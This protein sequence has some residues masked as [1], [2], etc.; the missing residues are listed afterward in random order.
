MI[1][2]WSQHRLAIVHDDRL[3]VLQGEG[4]P[5]V[6]HALLELF[7]VQDPVSTDNKHQNTNVEDILDTFSF[8]FASPAGLPPRRQYDHFIPLI[9]GAWSVSMRPYGIAPEL[10]SELE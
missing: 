10:K 8:V 7:L 3:V 1:T 9:P 4:A 6:T 2:H 5:E